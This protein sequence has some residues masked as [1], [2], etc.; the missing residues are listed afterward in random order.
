VT[1]TEARIERE[2]SDPSHF[3][4]IDLMPAEQKKSEARL[5]DGQVIIEPLRTDDGRMLV[6]TPGA[7]IHS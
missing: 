3:L 5:S 7:L 4:W 6:K 1:L 2:Q